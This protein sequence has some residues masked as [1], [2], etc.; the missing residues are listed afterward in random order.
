MEWERKTRK[1]RES[2]DELDGPKLQ[3][4]GVG[5]GRV[6]REASLPATGGTDNIT[7][8]Y[9]QNTLQVREMKQIYHSVLCSTGTD[10]NET[11]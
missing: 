11:H 7:L 9:Q 4:S 8:C 10:D 1:K 6:P 5:V 2:R 3:L